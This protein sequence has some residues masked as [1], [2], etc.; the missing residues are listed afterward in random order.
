MIAA[1]NGG[2]TANGVPRLRTDDRLNRAAGDQA[3]RGG[4]GRSPATRAI[5]AACVRAQQGTT[6]CSLILG[7]N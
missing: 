1:A 5:G 4:A 7:E 2:R 3:P 6:W